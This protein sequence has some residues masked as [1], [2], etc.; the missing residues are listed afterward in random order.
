MEIDLSLCLVGTSPAALSLLRAVYE[1][2]DPVSFEAIVVELAPGGLAERILAEFPATKVFANT[3]SRSY[4]KDRNL[5]LRLAEGRYVALLDQDA[6]VRP[7]CLRR[8]L[9]FMDDTPEAGIAGPKAINAYGRCEP[10]ARTLPGLRLLLGYYGP[11]GGNPPLPNLVKQHRLGD[12]DGNATREVELLAGGCHLIR[13]ELLEELGYLDES[14]LT[15][16]AE[17]E[18]YLRA[19]RAGWHQYFVHDA[20]FLHLNPGRYHPRLAGESYPWGDYFRDVG[21]Y[22]SRKWLPRQSIY[23]VR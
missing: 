22:L 18:F 11:L 16:L 17:I 21:R 14:F 19:Q 8:L 2:A 15:P 1:T 7:G 23:P 9:D 20:E 10:S 5:A 12:W 3:T 4:S 13:Q 6:V